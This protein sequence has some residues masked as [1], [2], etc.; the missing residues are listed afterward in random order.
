VRIAAGWARVSR[1]PPRS[2]LNVQ[3]CLHPF[4]DAGVYFN[5]STDRLNRFLRAALFVVDVRLWWVE[6]PGLT[7]PLSSPR[8]GMRNA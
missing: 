5:L 4:L 3:V 8:G 6:Y 7:G 1:R 2:H